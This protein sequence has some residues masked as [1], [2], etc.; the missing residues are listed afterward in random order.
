M[1][2]PAEDEDVHLHGGGDERRHHRHLQPHRLCRIQQR[3]QEDLPADVRQ[4]KAQD[5]SLAGADGD[6]LAGVGGDL[7]AGVGGELLAGVDGDPLA[8]VDGDPL[9]GVGGDPL[10]GVS[11]DPLV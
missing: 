4:V 8:G 9:A 6:P 1:L 11:G 10:A 3:L 5:G 2:H 7:L